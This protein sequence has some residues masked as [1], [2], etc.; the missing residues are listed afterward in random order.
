[1]PRALFFV[2]IYPTREDA[3]VSLPGKA[4]VGIRQKFMP[5]LTR[6]ATRG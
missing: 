2:R 3:E 4:D 6:N 1:M 5:A